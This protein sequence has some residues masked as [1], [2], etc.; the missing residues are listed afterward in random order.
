M[1]FLIEFYRSEDGEIKLGAVV[2]FLIGVFLLYSFRDKVMDFMKNI[3][4]TN[5]FNFR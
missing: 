1:K 4:D 3:F 5:N 2:M